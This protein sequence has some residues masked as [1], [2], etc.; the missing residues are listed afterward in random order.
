MMEEGWPHVA[1]PCSGAP[2]QHGR[3]S[4]TGEAIEVWP[5]RIGRRPNGSEAG[6]ALE[7]VRSG[8]MEGCPR[9]WLSTALSTQIYHAPKI[10]ITCT[11]HICAASI[12]EVRKKHVFH[13]PQ[14]VMLLHCEKTK[15]C[16]LGFIRRNAPNS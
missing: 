3:V 8:P 2:W 10:K 9:Q 1:E 13:P 15:M 11:P 14:N 5:R 12:L 16:L 4:D 6:G 7:L